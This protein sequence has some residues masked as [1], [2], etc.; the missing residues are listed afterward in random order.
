MKPQEKYEFDRVYW[1]CRWTEKKSMRHCDWTI[2]GV[3]KQWSGPGEYQV[4][5]CFFGFEMSVWIRRYW[6]G[7][8]LEQISPRTVV[9]MHPTDTSHVTRPYYAVI[10]DV[11]NGGFTISIPGKY[12]R[13]HYNKATVEYQLGRMEIIGD[14]RH[15]KSLLYNQKFI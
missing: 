10:E 8:T 12:T 5:F 2:I 6:I 3:R 1:Y 9:R 14:Y 4:K 15:H 11:A 7:V 13:Y